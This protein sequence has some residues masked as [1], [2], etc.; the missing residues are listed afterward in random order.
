MSFADLERAEQ[1]Y[2]VFDLYL[3]L[4]GRRGRVYVDEAEVYE[5]RE[6]LASRICDALDSLHTLQ[7]EEEG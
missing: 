7:L 1:I 3:W 5:M 6:A 2:K 4:A